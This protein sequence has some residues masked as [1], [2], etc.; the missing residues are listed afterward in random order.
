M[1]AYF[2]NFPQIEYNSRIVK[3]I[4]IRIDALTKI[5]DNVVLFQQYN[6]SSQER[7]EDIA[8]KF[9]GDAD[10]YWIILYVNEIIDPYYDWPLTDKRLYDHVVLN[11]GVENVTATHH[12]ETTDDHELG[13]GIIVSQTEPF[14]TPISNYTHEET[15]NESKRKIKILKRN[16]IQQVLTEYKNEL[17][18]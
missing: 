14:S 17:S 13:T 7:P 1:A 18:K 16:Y 10:L 4:T 12:Y 6:I 8:F 15:I 3:D 11:Y 2:S 5:K 9:Y